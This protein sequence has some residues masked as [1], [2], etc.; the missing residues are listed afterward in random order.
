MS[1][2]FPFGIGGSRLGTVFNVTD[3]GAKGDGVTDDAPAI[4]AA[5]NVAAAAGGSLAAPGRHSTLK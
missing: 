1:V 3:Y 2:D 5:I 4:Q